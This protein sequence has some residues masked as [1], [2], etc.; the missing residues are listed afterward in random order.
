MCMLGL[1]S[2]WCGWRDWL[3]PWRICWMDLTS[4]HSILAGQQR[5]M[6]KKFL[7]KKKKESIQRNT[8]LQA[9]KKKKY[10][11]ILLN[12]PWLIFSSK[13][14]PY[15]FPHT[16]IIMKYYPNTSHPYEKPIFL[17]RLIIHDQTIILI[18]CNKRINKHVPSGDSRLAADIT[19]ET[20][21]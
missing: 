17:F 9:Q 12:L 1:A 8:Q 15:S 20:L 7:P 21:L 18:L 19:D 4:I 5:T 3:G 13:S 11:H 2:R 14:L 6:M 10:K 16:P